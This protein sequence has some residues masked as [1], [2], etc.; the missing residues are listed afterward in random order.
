MKIHVRPLSEKEYINRIIKEFNIKK[1]PKLW[2]SL[3]MGIKY[4][5]AKISPENVI[6]QCQNTFQYYEDLSTIL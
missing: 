4:Y 2:C 5:N 6:K 3:R 1:D